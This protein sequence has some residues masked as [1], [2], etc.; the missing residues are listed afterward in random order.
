MNAIHR[1]APLIL[2]LAVLAVHWPVDR[3]DFTYDDRDFVQTNPA[4]GSLGNAIRGFALPFPPSQ[5]ERALY[6]PLTGMTYAVDVA[7]HGLYGP[8]FHQTNVLLY[9]LLVVL[10]Y[11]LALAYRLGPG[12]AFVVAAL[13]A[14]HPVHSDAVDSIS[15]RSELLSL[16]FGVGALLA[17]LRV[18]ANGWRSPA[19]LGSAALYAFA[20]LSKETGTI[21][22]AVLAVHAIALRPG[23][24][25]P[26]GALRGLLPHAFVLL[27]Y[28]AI[29]S[30]VLGGV[31]PDTTVLAG[32]GL[33]AHLW[34][35]GA[36]FWMDIVQLGAPVNLELDFYYQAHIGI[37]EGASWDAFFGW[38]VLVASV[39]AAIGLAWRQVRTPEISPSGRT[40][41]L[42]G[43]ALLLFP[44]FPT[45]H[46][47]PIGAL[48]A[49]RFLFAP[50]LGFVLLAVLAGRAALRQCLPPAGVRTAATVVTLILALA[51]GLRSHQ[52]ALEWRDAILLWQSASLRLA[53]KRVHTNLAAA[54]IERGQNHLARAQIAL[55]LDLDP[56]YAPALGNRGM[57][58]MQQGDLEAARKTF[59]GLVQENPLDA[60]T[61]F[62]LGQIS[63][64]RD[65]PKQ[66]ALHFRRA[67]DI[68]PGDTRFT[69]ALAKARERTQAPQGP[70]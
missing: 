45:S 44:L 27:A 62:N 63:L 43:F 24:Q 36:V 3:G 66:A 53:D 49:E 6:R 46:V 68:V 52:R 16:L 1:V 35:M 55:A 69:A 11:R 59:E 51:G 57:L 40:T 8:G 65:E 7:I 18:H 20:C 60:L 64:E 61:W 58:E 37:R 12:F 25:T 19:A 41:A 50:S 70:R 38:S 28:A 23:A 4:I 2:V 67:L 10:V 14:M 48:F 15:G 22:L 34:T 32:T 17:F 30:A 9:A 47:L 54:Y 31:S 5:P 56:N 13:F 26:L 29:R 42:C 21:W 33:A 39:A